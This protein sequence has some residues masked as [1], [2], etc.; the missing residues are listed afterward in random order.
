M[1]GIKIVDVA[2]ASG[3]NFT[4]LGDYVFHGDQAVVGGAYAYRLYK[5]GV[6]TPTDGDWYLRSSLVD[7]TAAA[8]PGDTANP[9]GAADPGGTANPLDKTDPGASNHSTSPAC[10]SMKPMHRLCLA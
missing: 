2:G 8:N 3:G 5:N 1:E 4:L 9:G 6:T 7:P 10:L